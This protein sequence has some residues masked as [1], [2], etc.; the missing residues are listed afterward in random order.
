MPPRKRRRSVT[1]APNDS[2]GTSSR[3]FDSLS[4]GA[5]QTGEK[6]DSGV[7]DAFREEHHEGIDYFARNPRC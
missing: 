3:G 4:D 2:D 7:W 6:T 1:F 5:P